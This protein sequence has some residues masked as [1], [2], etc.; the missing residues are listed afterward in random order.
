MEELLD[1]QHRAAEARDIS[2]PFTSVI[3]KYH[4]PKWH[5]VSQTAPHPQ[6]PEHIYQS[7]THT[8]SEDLE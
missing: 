3:D 7:A 5:S 2:S 1:L 6:L 8:D 4:D